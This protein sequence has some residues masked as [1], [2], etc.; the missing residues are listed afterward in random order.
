MRRKGFTFAELIA[1]ASLLV[2]AG[3][4]LSSISF[5][6]VRYAR[7]QE[8]LREMK[9]ISDGL[10][11]YYSDFGE[12]PPALTELIVPPTPRTNRWRGPYVDKTLIDLITDPWSDPSS[13]L[14]NVYL[15]LRSLYQFSSIRVALLLSVGENHTLESNLTGWATQGDWIPGGDDLAIRI[16]PRNMDPLLSHLT[17]Q[18]LT[19]LAGDLLARNPSFAPANYNTAPYP[20]EWGGRIHYFRCNLKTAVLY[21]YGPDQRDDSAGG[22]LL[23]SGTFPNNDDVFTV[24]NWELRFI[25]YP[26]TWT[27]GLDVQPYHCASYTFTVTNLYPSALYITYNGSLTTSVPSGSTRNITTDT[28]TITV[29]YGSLTL[30]YFRP[31]EID[32]DSNCIVLKRYGKTG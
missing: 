19:R 5:S 23:C 9:E 15:Y 29:R 3:L 28:R 30:D 6:M 13:P 16:T 32:L 10:L 27:G 14:A 4:A 24:V 8:A 22:S 18:T 11:R 2:V 1:T 20:D 17:Q 12:F 26:P 31:Y 7:R 21:S 25:P